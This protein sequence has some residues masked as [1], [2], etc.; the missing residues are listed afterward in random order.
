M[1][2]SQFWFIRTTTTTRRDA[3]WGCCIRMSLRADWLLS[4]WVLFENQF[5]RILVRVVERLWL[6]WPAQVVPSK[7]SE[8]CIAVL[9]TV[10][11][12]LKGI[13]DA[14]WETSGVVSMQCRMMLQLL[15][16]VF[17][18]FGAQRSRFACCICEAIVTMWLFIRVFSVVLLPFRFVGRVSVL[19]W[20]KFE[21]IWFPLR[22]QDEKKKLLD[23]FFR[24]QLAAICEVFLPFKYI[25]K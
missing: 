22:K 8:K 15:S 24:L 5:A 25:W 7:I 3:Q 1:T 19:F 10:R 17:S 23:W 20:I 11:C 9:F 12:V 21:T 14:S 16:V 13:C 6:S 18:C 4:K 2:C